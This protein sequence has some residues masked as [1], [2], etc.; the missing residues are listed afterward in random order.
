MIT[1]NHLFFIFLGYLSGSVLYAYLL[2]KYIK[3]IDVTKESADGNPGAANAIQHGGI[4]LGSAALVLGKTPSGLPGK[5]R[6]H[7]GFQRIIRSVSLQ[8]QLDQTGDQIGVP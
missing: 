4:L 8:R 3:K 2:P 5:G 6:L 1:I 7:R